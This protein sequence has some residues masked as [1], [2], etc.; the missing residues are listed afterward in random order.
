M[1]QFQGRQVVTLHNQRDFLFFRR[2]RLVSPTDTL[3]FSINDQF[4]YAFRSTEKVAL[5]EIGPRFTLKM[6]SLRK[7]IP[8]VQKF[9]E[10]SKPIEFDEFEENEAKEDVDEG[11]KPKEGV[12]EEGEPKEKVQAPTT[13]EFQWQ[14]KVCALSSSSASCSF[15]S[16]AATGDDQTYFLSIR[17]ACYAVKFLYLASILHRQPPRLESIAVCCS[18]SLAHMRKSKQMT[19]STMIRIYAMYQ[20]CTELG[21]TVYTIFCFNFNLHRAELEANAAVLRAALSTKIDFF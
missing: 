14:W 7:G 13:D 3:E 15:G 12:E 2:H 21:L 19:V 9:G 18:N 20:I 8:A 6:K 10:P 1:P 16:L 5:Q 17:L 11:D 4:R